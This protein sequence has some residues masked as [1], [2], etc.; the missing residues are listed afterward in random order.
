MTDN[1]LL[2]AI[3]DMMELHLQPVCQRLDKLDSRIDRLE[4]RVDGL[5]EM[6]TSLDNYVRIDMDTRLKHVELTVE[7]RM[8]PV[9]LDLRSCYK[10]TYERYRK[11]ADH[12]EGMNQ[13]VILLKRTVTEHSKKLEQLS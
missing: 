5:E 6:L 7:N 12:L 13:D 8:L 1:E 11:W 9:L 3:S 10:D 4:S 2:V